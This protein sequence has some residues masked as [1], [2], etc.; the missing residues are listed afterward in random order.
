MKFMGL[1]INLHLFF[2][3][4]CQIT[5]AGCSVEVFNGI[6]LFMFDQGRVDTMKLMVCIEKRVEL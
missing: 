1:A 5:A 2:Y 4:F 3:C 6:A